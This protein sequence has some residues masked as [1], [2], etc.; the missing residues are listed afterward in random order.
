MTGARHGAR[1]WP[2]ATSRAAVFDALRL[3]DDGRNEGRLPL[4][5]GQPG[6]NSAAATRAAFRVVSATVSKPAMAS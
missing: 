3:T 6:S 4:G 5:C 1:P 2:A